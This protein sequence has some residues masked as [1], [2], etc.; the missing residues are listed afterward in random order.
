MVKFAEAEKRGRGG[1]GSGSGNSGG[2]SSRPLMMVD[3]QKINRAMWEGLKEHIMRDRRRKQ[4]G[5][6][7]NHIAQLLFALATH[8]LYKGN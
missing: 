8:Y 1:E 5:N 4:E 7:L 6:L 3:R 2:S